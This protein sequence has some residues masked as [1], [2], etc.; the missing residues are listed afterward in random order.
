[1]Q[2]TFI[3]EHGGLQ[4]TGPKAGKPT[5]VGGAG[6]SKDRMDG[7]T[8]PKAMPVP[9]YQSASEKSSRPW[10][11]AWRKLVQECQ[12]FGGRGSSTPTDSVL[13]MWGW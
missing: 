9:A 11:P 8:E 10:C 13:G 4:T 6:V 12:V 2:E 7:G 5:V 1:M 3:A